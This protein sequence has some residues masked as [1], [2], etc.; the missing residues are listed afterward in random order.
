MEIQMRDII[1]TMRRCAIVLLILVLTVGCW[2][3][4]PHEILGVKIRPQVQGLLASVEKGYGKP[5]SFSK[6]DTGQDSAG[7][8]SV[9]QDGTPTVRVNPAHGGLTEE[10]VAHELIHLRLKLEGFPLVR[11][12]GYP[13]G[14]VGARM[15]PR[16]EAYWRK[17]FRLVR[18]SIEHWSFYPELRRMGIEPGIVLRDG[19]DAEIASG[20]D[21]YIRYT[22]QGAVIGR[23]VEYMRACLELGAGER[24]RV[25]EWYG[26]E[27]W[28]GD[29]LK[30]DELAAVV[31]GSRRPL[32]PEA[33]ISLAL[34]I[35]NTLIST[36]NEDGAPLVSVGR[37]DDDIRGAYKGRCVDLV[38]SIHQ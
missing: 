17:I 12:L 8:S 20:V 36:S 38:I 4:A 24:R 7:D 1:Q 5:V 33:E 14:Y 26:K 31:T 32:T 37:W 35:L 2:R 34:R 25:A 9:G 19:F 23:R 22:A 15:D 27:N 10:N 30:G 6:A 11:T 3:P 29:R 16:K 13:E 21:P 28:S 18:D